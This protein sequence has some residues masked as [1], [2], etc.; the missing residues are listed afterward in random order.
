MDLWYYRP[1][2]WHRMDG[3]DMQSRTEGALPVAIGFGGLLWQ[4]LTSGLQRDAIR[5]YRRSHSDSYNLA[6]HE[7]LNPN[8]KPSLRVAGIPEP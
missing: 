5:S 1:P 8:L 7:T 6:T 4:K 3:T 2:A